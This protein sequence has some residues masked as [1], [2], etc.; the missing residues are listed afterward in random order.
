MTGEVEAANSSSFSET[1]EASIVLHETPETMTTQNTKTDN[2]SQFSGDEI[3]EDTNVRAM[4]QELNAFEAK[5][6]QDCD[7]PEC[8]DW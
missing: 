2:S 8:Q 6:S 3:S 7:N 5:Y 1:L 4:V